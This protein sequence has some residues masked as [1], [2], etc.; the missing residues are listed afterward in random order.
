MPTKSLK[1]SRLALPLL[2]TAACGGD[3]AEETT[4]TGTTDVTEDTTPDVETDV[5]EDTD[6]VEDAVADVPVTGDI[7]AALS[8]PV[9]EFDTGEA[10]RRRH[11]LGGDFEVTL[12]DGSSWSLSE[13]WSGCESYV[14]VPDNIVYSD[15]NGASIWEDGVAQ[16][17]SESP[18]NVHYFFVSVRGTDSA[19]ETSLN[20]MQGRVDEALAALPPADAAHWAERLHVVGTRAGAT[21]A[22]IGSSLATG[23]GQLGMTID[24]FQRIRGVGS[25]AD[26]TRYD[27]ELAN[28]EMWPWER[29]LSYVTNEPRYYNFEA[30]RQV[31]LDAVD[32]TEVHFWQGE[33]IEQFEDIE[34]E[35]P[36]A[37][38]MA[39]FDTL[40]LDVT[41]HCP[42]PNALEAGNCGAWDY[43]AH[44]WLYEGE[45]E[46]ETRVEIARHI[47]TYH[48]EGRWIVDMTPA[49]VHLR[50]GG[51]RH[52]RWEWA[53][54]WNVQP[55]ATY[56][57]L[58]FSNQDKGYQ[59]IEIG[60]LWG[61]KGFNSEYN[62]DRERMRVDIPGNAS[63]VEL[64]AVITGHGA[65]TNQCAEFCN[66]QHEFVVDGRSFYREHPA[67]G[68]QEGCREAID[69]GTVPN[70]WGTW[71]FGRGGWC[72]GQGVEPYVV[73]VTELA[74]PGEELT[75]DYFGWLG[76]QE[77]PDNAG[78]IVM[79]SFIV[80]YE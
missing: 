72:P 48:R 33:V 32:A 59:P 37:E 18:L 40:E 9:R 58:R 55:T 53:P 10:G 80:S 56:L 76:G 77:P 17:M 78:N 49:L 22:W 60:E 29:N 47:T 13:N 20:A 6:V 66:H 24:R 1:L 7:C 39:G 79:R 46:D 2:L 3:E 70:Q 12:L 45:G 11:E 44:L 28:A 54:E 43:L 8:L 31:E 35:L 38:E 21:D 50:D 19:A 64:W 51:T 71:W 62:V 57:T 34:I 4:D 14:F 63:R 26:V 36:S 42:N 41:Q 69:Q 5:E 67:I 27:Q 65:D 16:L 30:A 75:V 25:L 52:F 73:D 23:I 68:N 61:G 74:T 15:L